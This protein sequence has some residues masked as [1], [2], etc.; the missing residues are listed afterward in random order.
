MENT[1]ACASPEQPGGWKAR[2]RKFLRVLALIVVATGACYLAGYLHGRSGVNQLRAQLDTDHAAARNQSE[3][4]ERQLSEAKRQIL[5]LDA[6]RSLDQAVTAIDAR[7]F[8]IAEQQ[9]K[10]AGI[11]LRTS[12]PGTPAGELGATLEKFHFTATEDLG[13]Q[14]RQL[15]EWIAQLDQRILTSSPKP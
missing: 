4:L 11:W 7:N 13:P 10:Q 8:G 9:L 3:Q 6:R 5:A 15:V 14:R 12:N 1:V 2:T